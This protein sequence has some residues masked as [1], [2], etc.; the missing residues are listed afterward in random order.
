[1]G[2]PIYKKTF[3]G[4]ITG[5]ANTRVINDFPI[6]NFKQLVMAS[7]F[8]NTGETSTTGY[9][10][11]GTPWVSS[12]G[13]IGAPL[14]GIRVFPELPDRTIEVITFGGARTSAPYVFT[15][16]YTKKS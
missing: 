9:S 1:M 16:W 3:T 15:F 4:T 14:S 10:M 13:A 2:D 7:G 12:S 6:A 11:L 8:W 5:A